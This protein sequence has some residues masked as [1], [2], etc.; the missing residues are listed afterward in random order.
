[1]EPVL[2][3]MKGAPG[4]WEADYVKGRFTEPFSKDFGC[5]QAR[6]VD[7]LFPGRA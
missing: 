7:I 4:A 2:L 1:M 5:D 6:H 3:L